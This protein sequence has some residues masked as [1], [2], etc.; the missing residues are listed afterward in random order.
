MKITYL[1]YIAGAIVATVVFVVLSQVSQEYSGILQSYTQQA[2]SLGVFSYITAMAAS[3][4]VAPLGTGFLLPVAANSW[5]PLWAA[6]YSI[7]GWTIGS[8]IAFWLSKKYGLKLVKNVKTIQKLRE[9]ERA[10][11]RRHI[12]LVVVLLRIALPVDLLSYALGIFSTMGYWTFFWSTV[13]GITPFAVLTMY[14]ATS[15][16]TMQIAVSVL[17]AMSMFVGVYYIYS[18][19]TT[20]EGKRKNLRR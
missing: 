8:M 19:S 15:T 16:V 3:I 18:F 11:P 5:G 4:V 1:Y 6:V 13:I 10:M 12:F 20:K 14:A 17:G 7:T 9:L 2:G